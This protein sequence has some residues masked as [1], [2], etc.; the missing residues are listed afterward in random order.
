MPFDVE[1]VRRGFPIF[2]NPPFDRPLHY[3][4]NGATSQIHSAVLDVIHQH[5]TR[6]RAN[7][8]RGVHALAEAATEAYEKAREKVAAYIHAPT[9]ESC[10]F[11]S[12]TTSAINLVAHSFGSTLQAGDEILI[13]ELEHHSNIVPW[14]LLAQRSGVVIRVLPVTAEGRVDL[15][16]LSGSLTKRTKLV[17][18]AHVS[19][20]TGAVTDVAKVVGEARRYGA[21]VMLDGAQAVPHGPI[22]VQSLGCDFYAFSGHKMFGPNGI[23]VLWAKPELLESLPPFLGGGE[24]IA[25]VTFDETTFAPPPHKFEAGTPPIAQAVGLGAACDWIRSLD[26]E[27]V[28]SHMS[29]LLERALDGLQSFP[30]LKIIG[31][32]G[33]QSRAPVI[34]FD[35]DGTHPHDICTIL[36]GHGVALRGGHHCAQPLMDKFDLA[37]TTRASLA[38]YNTVGDIDALLAGLEDAKRRLIGPGR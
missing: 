23:G 28:S 29:H 26:Q 13:S 19:N 32:E 11:T 22:D 17:S 9:P 21:L 14:Q 35:I 34:S 16:H 5:E 4:D 27:A 7:V 37:G 36:D 3:L 38:V 10:V 24:M 25:S 15:D 31:P 6:S 20:V 18:I 1:A 2:E 8:M 33:L 12:G 30:G